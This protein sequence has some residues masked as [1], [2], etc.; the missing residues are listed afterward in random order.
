MPRLVDGVE[1]KEELEFF[2]ELD[3][4]FIQGFIFSKPEP[5]PKIRQIEELAYNSI[6][7]Y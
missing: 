6:S 3:V 2:L 1:K 7:S 4:D 5:Y